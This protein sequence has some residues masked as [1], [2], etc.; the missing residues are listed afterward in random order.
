MYVII[1]MYFIPQMLR[2][3]YFYSKLFIKSDKQ[4]DSFLKTK[5][6]YEEDLVN[7]V[8]S[9]KKA[10]ITPKINFKMMLNC[11]LGVSNKVSD[12]FDL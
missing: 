10:N 12:E 9:S 5:S 11:I 6:T 7:T 3:L 1:L 4:G 8:K 2:K